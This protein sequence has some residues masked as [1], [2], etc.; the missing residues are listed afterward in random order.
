MLILIYFIFFPFQAAGCGV[1][2]LNSLPVIK[3]IMSR[4]VDETRQ[5]TCN[6]K[7]TWLYES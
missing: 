2:S 3:G 6:N 1:I 4:L 5:G 7:V